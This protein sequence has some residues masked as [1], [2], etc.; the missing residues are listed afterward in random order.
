MGLDLEETS[1]MAN[2]LQAIISGAR[3]DLSANEA[4]DFRFFVEKLQ[5]TGFF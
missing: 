4:A 1:F 2:I 5:E 3:S